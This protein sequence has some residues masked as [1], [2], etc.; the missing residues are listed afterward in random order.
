MC[1]VCILADHLMI[2]CASSRKHDVLIAASSYHIQGADGMCLLQKADIIGS[3]L[4]IKI[5]DCLKVGCVC[6]VGGCH[7]WQLPC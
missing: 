1:C 6:E 5:I 7:D 2:G 4:D 3:T